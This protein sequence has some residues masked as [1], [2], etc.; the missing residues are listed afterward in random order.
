M[1][2]AS[3]RSRR[4]QAAWNVSTHMPRARPPSR[5]PTRSGHLAGGLVGE[6]DRDD[7]AGAHVVVAHEVRDAVGQDARLAGARLPRSPAAGRRPLRTARRCSGFRSSISGSAMPSKQGSNGPPAPRVDGRSGRP[8]VRCG[9]AARPRLGPCG[10]DR[11]ADLLAVRDAEPLGHHGHRRARPAQGRA[12]HG[13]RRRSPSRSAAACWHT[14]S[15]VGGPPSARGCWRSPTPSPTS[16]TRR[17]CPT[18]HGAPLDVAIDAAGA[19]AGLAGVDAPAVA[20]PAAPAAGAAGGAVKLVALDTALLPADAVW[21]DALRYLAR[22]LGAVRPLDPAD[23]A[24]G[25]RPPPSPRSTPGPARTRTTGG[26][27]SCATSRP[28]RRSRWRPTPS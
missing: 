8:R 22:R 25:P 18:R 11:R 12:P 4:A 3:R 9:D 16:C 2:S 6:R 15:R 10:G 7:L 24:G 14:G 19:A 1:R 21:Q 27:S 13:L 23:A 26:S 20:A 5:R 28:T 17:R